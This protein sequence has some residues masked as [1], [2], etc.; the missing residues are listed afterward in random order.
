MGRSNRL[1]IGHISSR[2]REKDLEYE[3]GRYGRIRDLSLK[4]GFAFLEYDK[5]E[6]ADYAIRKM[7]GVNLEGLRITVEFAKELPVRQP[8]RVGA[9]VLSDF[10]FVPRCYICVMLIFFASM[11]RSQ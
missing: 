3:F 9:Q 5:A 1:Y 11:L 4:Q 8:P 6:D 10:A 7:D 2:I